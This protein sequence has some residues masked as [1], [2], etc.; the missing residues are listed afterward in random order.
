MVNPYALASRNQP[1]SNVQL[2]SSN[3]LKKFE[4][5]QAKHTQSIEKRSSSSHK[6][7]KSISLDS[8]K[9][10]DISSD[11]DVD[12]ND[13]NSPE[14]SDDE[15]SILKNIKKSSNKFMKTKQ[16]TRS[17]SPAKTT[18]TT[19]SKQKDYDQESKSDSNQSDIEISV[20]DRSSTPNKRSSLHRP[21]SRLLSAA[22][23]V[24]SFV[25]ANLPKRSP[26][27]VKF[28]KQDST[29]TDESPEE[30]STILDNLLLD[31]EDLEP[32][33]VTSV[34]VS[35]NKFLKKPNRKL[36]KSPLS[37]RSESVASIIEEQSSIAS[38]TPSPSV[39]DANLIFDINDLERAEEKS[40]KSE[41]SSRK[42]K[43]EKKKSDKKE[44]KSKKSKKRSKT[45]TSLIETETENKTADSSIITELDTVEKRVDRSI[46]T[47]SEVESRSYNYRSSIAQQKSYYDDFE[48]DQD[49]TSRAETSTRRK[50]LSFADR[51]G[52]RRGKSSLSLTNVEIQVDPNDLLKHSQLIKSVNAYN[53]SSLILATVSYLNDSSS[54]RDLNQITGYNLINQTFNDLIRMNLNFMKNFLNT[55]RNLY[56][57][58]IQSIQPK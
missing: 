14:D 48:T 58:Q 47:E 22:S 17:P 3:A 25:N 36:A 33:T 11:L 7:K 1:K 42:S 10:L 24:S 16:P 21:S 30:E 23:S 43:K 40:E 9:D 57:Q 51:E 6:K 37:K 26:S 32:A 15:D 4:K 55:Q 28:V 53:P 27:R 49:V 31:I 46:M 35:P 34:S 56:E 39:L 41:K 18:T 8:S 20:M 13:K 2:S 54:L 52:S 44:K 45:P 12:E 29:I 38:S 5:F 19:K 50:Q